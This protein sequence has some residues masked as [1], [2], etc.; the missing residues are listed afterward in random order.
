MGQPSAPVLAAAFGSTVVA[1]TG[2]GVGAVAMLL[3]SLVP[4]LR[5]IEIDHGST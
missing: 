2:G 3:T 5:R 4:S 1:V